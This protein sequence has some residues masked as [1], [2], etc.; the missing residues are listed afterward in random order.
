MQ[1]KLFY[2]LIIVHFDA[3]S[4]NIEYRMCFCGNEKRTFITT[5][6]SHTHTLYINIH[7]ISVA[8]LRHSSLTE[9]L[10]YKKTTTNNVMC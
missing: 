2:Y 1:G 8:G 7:T 9:K 10:A 5:F 6:A 4:V 3:V